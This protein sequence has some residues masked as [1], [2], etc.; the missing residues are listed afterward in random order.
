[1]AFLKENVF[2]SFKSREKNQ[3]RKSPKKGR[4]A[5]SENV[6]EIKVTGHLMEICNLHFKVTFIKNLLDNQCF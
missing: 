5:Q 6:T 3:T 1:M 2:Q 4:E